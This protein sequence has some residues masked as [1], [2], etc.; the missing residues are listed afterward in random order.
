M[1]FDS[2]EGIGRVVLVGTLAY[3]ALLVV[4][5]TSGKRTLSQMNA[6][7]F[8]ITV[9][10]GSSLATVVLTKNIPFL[11]GAAAFFVLAGLQYVVAWACTRFPVFEEVVKSSPA[12]LYYQGRFDTRRLQRERL[13]VAEVRAAVRK[14]GVASLEQVTAV[15]LESAGQFSVLVKGVGPQSALDGVA[16]IPGERP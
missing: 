11:E 15:V 1:F 14:E 10:L 12:L 13:T 2:W 4:L 5:R 6:F 3:A 16:G 8:V 7:D 9:A